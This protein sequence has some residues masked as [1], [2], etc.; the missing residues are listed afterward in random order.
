MG[1]EA[2]V[3]NINGLAEEGFRRMLRVARKSIRREPLDEY[4]LSHREDGTHAWL[5]PSSFGILS[6]TWFL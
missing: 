4:A 5:C 3:R 6:L 1:R 2:R